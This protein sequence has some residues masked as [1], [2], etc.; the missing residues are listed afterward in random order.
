MAHDARLI[1]RS[2]N[3]VDLARLESAAWIG[4]YRR[5]WFR[6]LAASIGL[7]RCGFALGWPRTLWGAWLVL[8][9]NQLWAPY[10]DNHPK[11]ARFCMRRLYALVRLAY[12]EPT[13]PAQ[14]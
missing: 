6:V 5:E 13:K 11:R 4:Y 12:G 2:F 3:P 9:A 7:V 10:P 1:A 8:R 14:A